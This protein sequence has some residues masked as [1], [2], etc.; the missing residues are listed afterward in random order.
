MSTAAASAR[1][2]IAYHP[3]LRSLAHKQGIHIALQKAP[4]KYNL[5]LELEDQA[6]ALELDKANFARWCGGAEGGSGTLRAIMY[7]VERRSLQDGVRVEFCFAGLDPGAAG[8]L[9]KARE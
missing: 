4:K 9:K 7:E 8:G 3:S 6:V 1:R 5:K 2:I